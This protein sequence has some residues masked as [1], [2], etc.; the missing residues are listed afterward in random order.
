MRLPDADRA[1]VDDAKIRNYLLSP[2]HP[3]GRY[4]AR[5]FMAVGYRHEAWQLLREDLRAL[6][7]TV[8]VTPVGSDEYG[9]RYVGVG[10]LRG[11][12]GRT[13]PIVTIWLIPSVGEPPRLITA[14]PGEAT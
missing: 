14:Y 11:P 5:V 10:R 3:L 4:K 9:L 7:R 2:Q 8:E 6:A 1:L 13:L 12:T